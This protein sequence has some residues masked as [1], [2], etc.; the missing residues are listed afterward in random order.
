MNITVKNVLTH[1]VFITNSK[2]VDV[3]NESL[4]DSITKKQN[5]IDLEQNINIKKYLQIGLNEDMELLNL[6]KIECRDIL[7]NIG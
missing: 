5:K 1:L 4:L 2:V 3:T 7:I 6:Y